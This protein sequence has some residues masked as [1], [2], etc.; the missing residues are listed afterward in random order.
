MSCAGPRGKRAL[1][2]LVPVTA[3]G[4]SKMD[5]QGP[6][7]ITSHELGRSV[8]VA[9][10][11]AGVVSIAAGAVAVFVTS[12]QA[13]SAA[14]IVLG[15]VLVFLAIVRRIPLRF[16][17]GGTKFDATYRADEVFDI[18]R[19]TGVVQGVETALE[20]VE[21]SV[22]RGEAIDQTLQ[23]LLDQLKR[24][25]LITLF[26]TNMDPNQEKLSQ[27][28]PETVPVDVAYRGPTACA[29]AEITYRQLDYWARTG[30]VEASV[31]PAPDSG[32][33]RLYSYYDI[34]KLK[35]VKR[36]LDT[37]LS[38]QQVR[39]AVEYLSEGRGDDLAG[40]I[41]IGEGANIYKATSTKDV[42]DIVGSGQGFFGISIDSVMREV[43]TVLAQLPGERTQGV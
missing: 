26:D 10:W 9:C 29:A 15:G 11:V 2:Y 40:I 14:L 24:G 43:K 21:H 42:I 5:E 3:D 6:N 12:N 13:G 22:E 41:L 23:L 25:Q 16:E 1:H 28:E 31:R 33:M 27:S 32:T 37:G 20:N 8:G 7:R 36:L 34:L 35:I 38:L 30:L 19:E 39:Q 18:G 4:E 17:V